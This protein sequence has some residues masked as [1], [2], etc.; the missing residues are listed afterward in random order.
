MTAPKGK[1]LLKGT[2]ENITPLHIGS[3][4]DDRSDM[5]ILLDPDGKPFIPATALVGVLLHSIRSSVP[6][7]MTERKEWKWFWGSAE[8]EDRQ[9]KGKGTGYQSRFQCSDLIANHNNTGNQDSFGFVIRDGIKMDNARNM[10]EDKGKYDYELLEPGTRFN[11]KSEFSFEDADREFV[12]KMVS[13]IISCL[14]KGDILIGKMTNSGFGQIRLIPDTIAL[15]Q[16]DFKQK[17]DAMAWLFQDFS[18]KSKI[19]PETLPVPYVL[20]SHDFCI[21]AKFQL[22]HSLI[23][24]SY[25]ANPN[26]PDAIH[27]KSGGK[28]ILPG[29]SLKGAIRARAERIANTINPDKTKTL[30][31]ELFG[32]VDKDKLEKRAKK[33]KVR[34]REV[35]LPDYSANRQTRIQ[36]DRFTGGAIDG[37]LFETMPIFSNNDDPDF[38]VEIML[39]DSKSDHVKKEA[40]L[41][42]L[43][44]VLK[45]LWSGD[46]AV[47]GEKNVGRGVLKGIHATIHYKG[48][49]L[50]IPY[51]TSQI[52]KTHGSILQGFVE[53]FNKW[54]K[55]EQ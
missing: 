29:T 34:V 22:K 41:G 40:K 31:D 44:L 12:E 46:L 52:D 42:L 27:L 21:N 7:E 1:I 30:I 9:G 17:D 15:Y 50:I 55:N 16:F 26:D 23:V 24:R 2:V 53:E 3:G 4:N 36:I 32:M 6:S 10:V 48:D 47:G 49:K 14:T 37:K 25:S 19:F 51:D 18:K 20:Q 39:A 35:V 5:D 54:M 38:E 13:T 28:Q 11:L 43:L 45:D 8:K 33:G